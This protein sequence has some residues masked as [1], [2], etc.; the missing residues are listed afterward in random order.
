MLLPSNEW[1]WEIFASISTQ[2]RS[3]GMGGFIGFDYTA[4]H[5]ILRVKDVPESLWPYA[6][7]KLEILALVASKFW[8]KQQDS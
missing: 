6:L 4:L 3:G 5:F 8:N 7:E 2:I 1:V